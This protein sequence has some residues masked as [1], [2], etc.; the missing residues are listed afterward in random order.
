MEEVVHVALQ[1]FDNLFQAGVG[2]QMGECLDAVES[3]V[4]DDMREFLSI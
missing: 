1:Y 3:R 4:T 2:D